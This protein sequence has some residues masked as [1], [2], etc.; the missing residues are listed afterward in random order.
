MQQVC[1]CSFS[2]FDQLSD[3]IGEYPL[4]RKNIPDGISALETIQMLIAGKEIEM[5]LQDDVTFSACAHFLTLFIALFNIDL[6][7][8]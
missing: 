2:F 6:V 3:T 7:M 1:S 4:L 5:G 8:I